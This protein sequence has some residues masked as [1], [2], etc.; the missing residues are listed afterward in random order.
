M[1]KKKIFQTYPHF[2]EKMNQFLKENETIT[3]CDVCFVGDSLVEMMDVT[4]FTNLKCIN[5]GISSDQTTGVLTS[6]HDRVVVTKPKTVFVFAGSNDVCNHYLAIEIQANLINII[7]ILKEELG[8]VKIIVSTLLPPCY[9]KGDHID[10]AYPECRDTLHIQGTNE[11]I[12]KLENKD[13][14]VHVFDSYSILADKNGSLS[15]ED[16][17]DGV[18]L[19]VDAYDRLKREL[20]KML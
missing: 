4:T 9:Y 12:K 15:L 5:R 20:I 7:N 2:Y 13:N 1:A 10:Y 8:D 19:N 3:S 6:L 14:N 18:H 17:L 16:T 11:L